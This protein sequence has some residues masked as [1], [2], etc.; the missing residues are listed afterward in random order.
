[1]IDNGWQNY[2][3]KITN[4][5][6]KKSNMKIEH[7]KDPKKFVENYKKHKVGGQYT[8]EQSLNHAYDKVE[9]YNNVRVARGANTNICNIVEKENNQDVVKAN[10]VRK[11]AEK[12]VDIVATEEKPG[13]KTILLMLEQA[14]EIALRSGKT[15]INVSGCAAMPEKVDRLKELAGRMGL[16][17]NLDKPSEEAYKKFEEQKKLDKAGH[18][19]ST[20]HKH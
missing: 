19:P 18:S 7:D 4:S 11:P 20:P 12:K 2:I 6:A 10:I 14:R 13:D 8:A 15:T 3:E 5:I 17:V 16:N 1:M 9:I